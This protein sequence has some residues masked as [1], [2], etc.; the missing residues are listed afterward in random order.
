MNIYYYFIATK[1]EK[2]ITKYN[3]KLRHLLCYTAA[4]IALK[5]KR[6]RVIY[7]IQSGCSIGDIRKPYREI[8][9]VGGK[10]LGILFH[11]S[12]IE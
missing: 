9:T 6:L 7:S 3:V 11:P 1:I 12:S 5:N 8:F 2:S 4:V 10:Y